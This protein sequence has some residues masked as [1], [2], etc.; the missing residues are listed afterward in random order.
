MYSLRMS[1]ID[2][3]NSACMQLHTRQWYNQKIVGNRHI[4]EERRS[5][6][7]PQKGAEQGGRRAF[8][9]EEIYGVR[10]NRVYDT[11]GV[12]N[13]ALFALYCTGC[14]FVDSFVL[15]LQSW[16]SI[17]SYYSVFYYIN[18]SFGLLRDFW[19]TSLLI[20]EITNCAAVFALNKLV[21]I[22]RRGGQGG[23]LAAGGIV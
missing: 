17:E 20:N 18:P 10:K 3:K 1:L 19:T 13:F 7:C 4:Q 22:G 21:Q 2:S 23:K 11:L 8:I 16:Q 9:V 12:F 14:R 6:H 15:I 5:P